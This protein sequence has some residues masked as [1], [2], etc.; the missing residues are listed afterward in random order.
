MLHLTYSQRALRFNFP[1]RTSRGALT[2]HVAY[3]LHL[4]DTAQPERLG[5][6]EAAPL[7][8]LSPDFGPGFEPR[9]AALCAAFNRR[10]LTDLLPDTVND[11]INELLESAWPALRFALETAVLDWQSGGQR[12][13]F[14]NA[15]SRGE[16]GIPI[17]GL[18][19]MGEAAFMQTQ[20]EKKLAE[21]YSCL[22]MKIGG[23]DF[24]TELRLLAEIR[25]VAGPDQLTLRVDANG[26]FAPHEALR[27]LEQLARFELHSIEQPIAAGQTS[28][29]ADLCR[30][31]PIPIAL[32]EEL[33]GVTQPEQQAA[34]LAQIQPAYI[35]IKPT[36]V[37]GLHA[38]RQWL[39]AAET[40][41]AAWWLTSALESN[42]GLNAVSQLA[43]EYACPDL[44]QGLGTG[45]LYH[46]N[47]VAPLRI[48]AGHLHY[49]PAGEWEIP[50]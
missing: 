26:A 41:N 40:N 12:Q 4:R 38:T 25:A 28:L 43:G 47:V 13:L 36:L 35:I 15:F 45:Q 49:D 32:D 34:L 42:V 44:P 31:S 29:M 11:L 6:G 33:I 14:D 30:E 2:E 9:V 48:A 18:V 50:S 1:A 5:L 3:Y 37:G 16:V 8:G 20:I 22:K 19:W 7:A 10:Q 17:N 23:I 27:K 24:A 46:N 39:R 21:S